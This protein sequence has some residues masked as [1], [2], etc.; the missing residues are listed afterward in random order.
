M[1]VEVV[2]ANGALV[3][4]SEDDLLVINNALNEVCHGLD[5]REFV[6]R[7][8]TDAASVERL[9]T[10]IGALYEQVDAAKD[11]ELVPNVAN[12]NAPHSE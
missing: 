11:A 12:P 7:M 1:R 10:S 8:G 3:H 6:A 5:V 2:S 4:L 9:L